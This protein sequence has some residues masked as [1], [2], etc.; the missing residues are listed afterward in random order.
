MLYELAWVYAQ[1]GDYQRAQR[2][3][4]VLSITDPQKLE[5]SDG[6]LLRADLMLRS[7]QI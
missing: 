2:A 7:R 3:L 1:L 5:L 4:E 6:S